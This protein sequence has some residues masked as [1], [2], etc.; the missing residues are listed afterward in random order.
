MFR[1]WIDINQK[2]TNCNN[3]DAVRILYRVF[4]RR[5]PQYLQVGL[6][7]ALD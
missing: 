3:S 7:E 1:N 4:V 6:C 2:N 5:D